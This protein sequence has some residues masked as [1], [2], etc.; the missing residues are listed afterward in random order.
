M[1]TDTSCTRHESL[2]VVRYH[3]TALTDPLN[4]NTNSAVNTKT[5]VYPSV[6]NAFR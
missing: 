6:G 3:G 4:T 5:V 2:T 1:H